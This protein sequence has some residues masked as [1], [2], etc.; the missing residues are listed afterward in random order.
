[1]TGLP[2]T[3]SR[4]RDLISTEMDG[5]IVALSIDLGQY[6]GMSGIGTRLWE[7]LET[8]QSVEGLVALICAEY[9]VDA[10]TAR[11]DIV[12]FVAELNKNGLL[13]AAV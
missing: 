6:F 10:A 2:E 8:P 4:G 1:M 11:A 7:A 5:D 13:E 12:A 3:F 9:E